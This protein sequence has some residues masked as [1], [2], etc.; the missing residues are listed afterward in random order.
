MGLYTDSPEI[1]A[2]ASALLVYCAI[3]Q[4]ADATQ[5]LMGGLLRGCHDTTIIT[6]SNLT[7][8]WLIGFPLA[9]ILIRTDLIVPAMGPAGA[10]M[11]F[12]IALTLAAV[13][14]TCRFLHT[15]KKVFSAH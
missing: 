4:I 7:S 11:S 13:I 12:I 5:A 6:W 9:C 2:T 1:I 10:W 14:L 3:Y 15:R 8:Y